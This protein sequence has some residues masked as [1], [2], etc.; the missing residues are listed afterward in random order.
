M[1]ARRLKSNRLSVRSCSKCGCDCSNYQEGCGENTLNPSSAL[2]LPNGIDATVPGGRKHS[3]LFSSYDAWNEE[4]IVHSFR[5]LSPPTGNI[6]EA[7]W[8]GNNESLEE[9]LND[10][11]NL[12]KVRRGQLRDAEGRTPLHLAAA[13]GNKETVELLLDKG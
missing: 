2:L 13:C 11:E 4:N 7:A 1:S 5:E 9:F 6:L 12:E 3:V 8:S 10:S